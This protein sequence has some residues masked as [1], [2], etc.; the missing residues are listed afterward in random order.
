MSIIHSI[1]L[2]DGIQYIACSATAKTPYHPY[3][4]VM[5]AEKG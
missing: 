3:F 2:Y 4:I 5:K 1:V